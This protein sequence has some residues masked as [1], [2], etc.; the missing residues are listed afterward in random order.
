MTIYHDNPLVKIYS[1]NGQD[2]DLAWILDILQIVGVTSIA[3][4]NLEQR[5]MVDL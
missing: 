2:Y 5:Y 3:T 4:L 1:L